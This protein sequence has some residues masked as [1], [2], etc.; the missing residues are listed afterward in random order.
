VACRPLRACKLA[1]GGSWRCSRRNMARQTCSQHHAWGHLA[2]GGR[3][4]PNRREKGDCIGHGRAVAAL[5]LQRDAKSRSRRVQFW[6]RCSCAAAVRRRAWQ[7]RRRGRATF[8]MAATAATHPPAITAQAIAILPLAFTAGGWPVPMA[9]HQ[10]WLPWRSAANRAT[11]RW[12]AKPPTTG[13]PQWRSRLART[14]ARI[15]R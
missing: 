8:A 11:A 14:Q 12:Q 3:G 1:N 9:Q 2:A 13:R 7:G 5:E 15:G 4:S 10:F 6:Q